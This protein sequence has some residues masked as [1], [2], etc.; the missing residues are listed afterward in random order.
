MSRICGIV[1]AG[2]IRC[3]QPRVGS[4]ISSEGGVVTRVQPFRCYQQL[5]VFS[6]GRLQVAKIPINHGSV[7]EMIKERMYCMNDIKSGGYFPMLAV[8]S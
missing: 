6:R 7:H 1:D 8:S 4:A 2:S 5:L 3:G